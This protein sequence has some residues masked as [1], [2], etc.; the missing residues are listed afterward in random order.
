[1]KKNSNTTKTLRAIIKTEL[2]NRWFWI[3]TITVFSLPTISFL[4]SSKTIKIIAFC[5]LPI[6]QFIYNIKTKENKQNT[7]CVVMLRVLLAMKKEKLVFDHF[8]EEILFGCITI[9]ENLRES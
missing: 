2:T 5:C 3:Y 8:S 9:Y 4:V 7:S 1:M 6:I